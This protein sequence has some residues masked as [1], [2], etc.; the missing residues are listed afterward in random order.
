MANEWKK[1]QERAARFFRSLGLEAESN[2]TVSGVRT[3]HAVDVLVRSRHAGFT[4]TW[5]VE[6]KLWRARVSKV[7]VLALREIVSDT[8]ADR[9]VLLAE[10]GVQSGAREAAALTNVHITSL[11]EVSRTASA[12][13]HALRLRELYDRM[14]LCREIYWDIPKSDRI[15]TGLR[16][17]F[18]EVGY[19]GAG[20]LE[21]IDDILKKAFR[22]SFPF[23]LD[24]LVETRAKN[25]PS[26]FASTADVVS[27][28]EQ[29][30]SDLEAKLLAVLPP[31][32][33]AAKA[34]TNAPRTSDVFKLGDGC[35][36]R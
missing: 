19:S 33:R 12:E 30:L 14:Q 4:V 22:G 23:E 31:T 8:G 6:C 27:E 17:D 24:F 7:H 9:G 5:I 1:Y 32:S 34:L 21:A 15:A 3:K 26:R 35:S 29:A 20:V 25:L 13:I 2:V 28:V 18:Y 16:P 11:D 10:R 36:S